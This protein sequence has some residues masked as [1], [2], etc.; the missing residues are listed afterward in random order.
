MQ[1]RK[2]SC[3]D[4]GS[5]NCPCLLAVCGNCITCSRLSGSDVCDCDWR[6]TCVFNEFIQNGSVAALQRNSDVYEIQ[7]KIWYEKDL[8][9]MHIK[10]PKGFAQQASLP[11]SCVFVRPVNAPAC[12][13]MPVSVMSTSYENE[14]IVLLVKAN[15]P[16]SWQLLLSDKQV[17]MR[18]PYRNGLL[19]VEKL[20]DKN[21][22]KVLC[23]AKGAGIAPVINYCRGLGKKHSVDVVVDIEKINRFVVDDFL[24]ECQVNNLSCDKLPLGDI[25]EAVEKYD[26][27]LISAS[28]FFQENIIVP[29]SKRVVCNIYT[30]CCGEGICGACEYIDPEGNVFRMCKCREK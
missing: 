29:D 24:E 16:K 12:F 2:K 11:G 25:S 18:G 19:G 4:A 28:E 3:A 1:D 14:M 20:K 10:V 27:V 17:E 5:V 9:V 7:E 6:G 26:A 15:G 30:M 23:L 8:V 22:R 21:C 13:D